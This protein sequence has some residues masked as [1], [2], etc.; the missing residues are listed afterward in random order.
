MYPKY[1]RLWFVKK[2]AAGYFFKPGGSTVGLLELYPSP[3]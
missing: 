3:K 2:K 1:G